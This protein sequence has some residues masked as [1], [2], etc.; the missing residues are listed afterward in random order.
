M[1]NL[2]YATI[3]LEDVFEYEEGY[4]PVMGIL[5]GKTRK[6]DGRREVHY[7]VFVEDAVIWR[8]SG[9]FLSPSSFEYVIPESDYMDL[10]T[11]KLVIAEIERFNEVMMQM[12]LEHPLDKH[13]VE[14][15]FMDF[16]DSKSNDETS[17]VFEKI[18]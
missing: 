14:V 10:Y 15:Y 1:K 16:F 3:R 7:L 13:L 8:K 12:L 2:I 17:E 18:G 9:L 4:H 6:S 11:K 5:P